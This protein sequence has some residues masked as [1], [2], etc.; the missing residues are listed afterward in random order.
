VTAGH[1]PRS[2]TLIPRFSRPRGAQTTALAITAGAALLGS[3]IVPGL[4]AARD[5]GT[6]AAPAA[7]PAALVNPFIGTTN[8]ADDFPGPDVP[9]GM[10][11]WSPDT[12]SDPDGGGYNYSDRRITG[13]ALTHLGGIGCQGE[14]D[15]AVLPTVGAVHS[16]G[17]VGFSHSRESA[18]AGY[19][20]VGLANGVNTQLTSTTRTGMA[21][22]GFPRG[23]RANLVLKLNSSQKG[24]SRTTF[25]VVNRKEVE[26]A[27]T[28]GDFCFSGNQYTLHFDM[29]FNQRFFGNGTFRDGVM[30]RGARNLVIRATGSAPAHRTS[31]RAPEAANHPGYHGPLPRGRQGRQAPALRGPVGAYLTFTAR[32]TPVLAKVG[33]SYVSAADA[34]Q[35]LI[36]ENP[37]WSFTTIHNK[38]TSAWNALLGKVQ[39]TGG[40]TAQQQVF[41]TALYHSLLYPSVFSDVNRKYV[42][43][44]GRVH[45]VDS[46]HSAYYTNISGWDY[47]RSQAQLQAILDPSVAGDVAQSMLDVYHQTGQ[48]PK[49][50]EDNS[51]AYI[52]VGDPADPILADYYAFGVRNFS[53]RQALADMVHD[54]T[55]SV[56]VRPGGH[57]LNRPGYLPENGTYGCCNFYGPVSTSLEYNTSDFALS[58]LA[59][60][61][62]NT[63]DQHGFADRAQDW[64]N[65]LN[66]N[67]GF[68][69][70]R[71]SS[72][73]FAGGFS[74]ASP[75]LVAATGF[76]EGDSWIYTG[77][78]PFDIAGLV[79]AKGGDAAYAAY[80]NTVLSNFKNASGYA[81]VGNEPSI[82]LPWEYDYIGQPWKTQ[83]VV[84]QIQDQ[85]WTDTP[86][87]LADGNDDLGEMSA[88][89]VWSALGMYPMTPGTSTLALGSPL[90]STAAVQL[91]SGGT[92]T[93]DGSGAAT[94]APY[95]QSATWNGGAWDN[96]YAPA[97]I[98]SSGGTLSYTLA[99]SPATSWAS[100]PA[101]AP[102]SYGGNFVAPPQPAVGA[103]AS[104]LSSTL[105]L[106]VKS[107]TSARPSPVTTW[108]CN[109]TSAQ[110]WTR[111]TD[112]TVRALG[113]C[114][115]VHN[116]GTRAG[117][118]IDL[119]TCNGSRAQLWAARNGTLYNAQANKCVSGSS[120]TGTTLV[121]EACATTARPA[122]Q[123][124]LPASANPRAGTLVSQE[125]ARLCVNDTGNRI[126]NGS[127]IELHTCN[128]GPSEH[129]TMAPDGTLRVNGRCLD[130]HNSGTRNGTPIDIYSCNGTRAQQ[131]HATT[132]GQLISPYS[133][134]CLALP[135]TG[136]PSGTRLEVSGC[137]NETSE[138]WTLPA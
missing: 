89:Y 95:V 91:P 117:T 33:I 71:D 108:T 26:G 72:G 41:Y 121:L 25:H 30:Q 74:A 64:W 17:T 97:G 37:S 75:P 24:D 94:N 19:Y 103:V 138:H 50:P 35:N 115:D 98:T 53:A 76:V 59:G 58:A 136:A 52:M 113:K 111:G 110:E 84:R 88:W 15:V 120:K 12:T 9:F 36:R 133:G 93:I 31:S 7:D 21:S 61:L 128:T 127:P 123:W 130:V 106:N 122:E 1:S 54:A 6:D 116:S 48:L 92:L 27:V 112:G 134:L 22:F 18:Q 32:S 28:T 63:N 57:Y 85:I 78:V 49:W 16:T 132:G 2:P 125:A 3:L 131:W 47:Y 39:I 23:K 119:Y 68:D 102:P 44:N 4:A 81:Y 73:A 10:I 107:P 82:E 105:C 14:T 46:G 62:G 20:R 83:Q 56:R 129:W 104:G 80:L 79:A 43:A 87:G 100:A 34:H 67:S 29:Q 55:R 45:T 70:P 77:M 66:P 42:G 135:R 51:E 101:Q 40:T 8:R 114:L 99:S 124:A 118:P 5:A 90:F 60:A 137:K 96:A 38:A 86:A 109:A 126:K 13:F 69:Q 65:M 11:Q